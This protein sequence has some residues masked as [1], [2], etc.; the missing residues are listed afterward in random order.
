MN[1]II[2]YDPSKESLDNVIKSVSPGFYLADN[3]KVASEFYQT[4]N[5]VIFISHGRRISWTPQ[6]MRY[7]DEF[8]FDDTIYT[9]QE[10]PLETKAN[11]ARYNRSMP[12]VDDWF[13]VNSDR[14]KHQILIQGF[15]P[16]PSPFLFGKIDFCIGGKMKF[17][18]D[19]KIVVKGVEQLNPFETDGSI[20]IYDGSVLIF[21]LPQIVSFDSN[22]ERSV[23][24]G[25]Y[26][27]YFN[28]N[29][30]MMFDIVVDY[31]WMSSLER[32]YPI[33]I[34][35][36]ILSNNGYNT[37][38]NGGRKIVEL[39]N[40]WLISV[41]S[42]SSNDYF[43]KS[44]DKGTTWTQLCY[45]T[46]SQAVNSISLV[47]KGNVVYFVRGINASTIGF[48]KF[49]ATTVANA[50]QPFT[51]I[52]TGQTATEHCSMI[53]NS[54][55]TE[56]HVA[57]ASKT[58]SQPSVFNIRYIKGTIN[59]DTSV[60]WGSVEQVTNQWDKN[61]HFPSILLSNGIP[62]IAT[63]GGTPINSDAMLANGEAIT[64]FKKSTEL[65]PSYILPS[66]WTYK[67]VGDYQSS[68]AECPST[69]VDKNGIIHVA[70]HSL[71]PTSNYF[72]IAY[73]KSTDGGKTW[74]TEFGMTNNQTYSCTNPSI[75]VDKNNTL[76][77]IYEDSGYIRMQDSY[78][79]G[80]T[81][82]G[83][84]TMDAGTSPSM[85]FDPSYSSFVAPW[86]YTYTT[87]VK[88]EK[89]MFATAPN[90]PINLQRVN[91]DAT[92]AADFIWSYSDPDPTSTQSA[93]QLQILDVLTGL[94][95]IDTGKVSSTVSKRTVSSGLTNGK[96][97]QWRVTTWNNADV[98][99]SWSNY[100]TFYTSG[101]PTV[102]ISNITNGQVYNSP[103]ITVQWNMSDPESEGQS[104]YKLEVL[105]STNTLLWSS[106]KVIDS[107]S[108][109]KTIGY[110]FENTK[111]YKIQISVWDAKDVESTMKTV[112]V[113]ISYTPPSTPNI[114]VSCDIMSATVTLLISHPT[115]I[116][117][118]QSTNVYRRKVGD[119]EW[120]LI[121]NITNDRYI[122]SGCP[123]GEYEYM[124]RAIGTNG[125]QSN[126]SPPEMVYM[127]YDGWWVMDLDTNESFQF[128]Y[129]IPLSQIDREEERNELRTFSSKPFIRYGSFKVNKGSLSG[130]KIPEDYVSSRDQIINL[131]NLMDK[132][133]PLLLKND[134]GDS[135]MVN[136]FNPSRKQGVALTEEISIEWVEVV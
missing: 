47:S 22:F 133:K 80:V 36:T 113:S 77:V 63:G 5:E 72:N 40:G 45:T 110:T 42:S 66:T 13:I 97:Y 101:K 126:I 4:N 33:V 90:S 16:D 52:D 11:Y 131:L 125:T 26:R 23:S 2:N 49:D 56:L 76:H 78:T 1:E 86:V 53:I 21:E 64:I 44:T 20:Q 55:G 108:R 39:S 107:V 35:P 136:I 130:L 92:S 94:I 75:T 89:F 3:G 102:T 58:S 87:F 85:M 46:H 7:L 29:A 24:Y 84:F 32:V 117:S 132:R 51:N 30:E 109:S 25:K 12:D 83:T 103:S 120:K 71:R 79:S 104:A 135:W 119:G 96:Q 31:D 48:G 54:S 88:F 124:V 114:I 41:A 91:F 67:T 70:W 134:I 14:L 127:T 57:W 50:N 105:S 28:D 121:A 27:V 38:G 129:N 82:V 116:T 17:D 37:S 9:V 8:G 10:V 81:W 95:V 123:Y 118:V 93:Y 59:G 6:N 34:D 122:D 99:G 68:K 62:I 19:L 61:I 128:L 73:S 115:S 69:V 18:S 65:T 98:V 112:T 74:S 15:Q 60:T 100:E 106:G 111:T 43:Y